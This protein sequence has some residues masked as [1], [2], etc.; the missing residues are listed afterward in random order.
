MTQGIPDPVFERMVTLRRDL[1]QHPEL[2]WSEHRTMD[3]IAQELVALGLSP[4]TGV[5]GTGIVVD[6]PGRAGGPRIA[7]RADTD[8]L[9]VQEETALPFASVHDGV[10][11]ACGHDGHTSMLVGAAEL[12]LA[13][14]PP[15]PVRLLWQPA[16]ETGRGAPA[17]IEAGALQGVAAIFGGHLDRHY[18]PG[19]LVVSEGPVNASTDT[20]RICF[21]GQQGHGA[22]PHE[23]IDAV[24]VGSLFVTSLQ[25]IVSREVDPAKPSVITVGRFD[26]GTASNVI[27][28]SALL[29]GTIRAQHR[30]VRDH[31]YASI[32][33]I[34]GAIGQ[35]HGAR[36]DVEVT[37]G[38]PPLI[39]EVR[40]A[41]LARQAAIDV[42]G[43]DRVQELHTANM[44]GE[45]FAWYLEEVP[46]AYIRYGAQVPGR[47]S[48]PA[49]SGGFDIHEDALAVGARWLDRVARLAGER[50]ALD[51][52]LLT[53]P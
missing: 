14:P 17:M 9:P 16:E 29:E 3:R 23:S 21:R 37:E 11:H 47:E 44:G 36:V 19:V 31:L 49:H 40:P 39:N 33:R 35:L 8:A 2:S 38:T 24:V 20:F 18:P 34:A 28:G 15:G 32:E 42:V 12:L 25:T 22:R 7:L 6:L 1:H 43:A 51:P 30:S 45:D 13:D 26:A 46:G 48:F 53:R 5:A 41:V 50:L 10:M 52:G 4:H 27:A